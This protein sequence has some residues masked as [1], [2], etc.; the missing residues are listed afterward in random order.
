[1]TTIKLTNV[2][3]S[4][5]HLAEP[6]AIGADSKPKYSASLL[7]DKA[8]K[9]TVAAMQA[10][11]KEAAEE[12]RVSCFGGKIPK[13]LTLPL[14]DGDVERDDDEA[15]QGVYFVNASSTNK[16]P[17]FDQRLKE[18]DDIEEDLY[19]GCYVNVII[20]VRAYNHPQ[21]GKGIAAYLNGVQ[22]AA[23]GERL[24]GRTDVVNQFDV[25]NGGADDE[26]DELTRILADQL[27]G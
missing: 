5:P 22:K 23:D 4:Y 9:E 17:C 25:I 13:Q 26:D 27:A 24:D 12:G 8:D 2:R 11:I 14:R 10:A 21:G 18:I 16:V 19:A 15:Y 3:L 7:I 6:R 20:N 1:M